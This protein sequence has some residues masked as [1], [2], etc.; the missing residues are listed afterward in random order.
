[1][2]SD[3]ADINSKLQPLYVD[4]LDV[5]KKLD[6]AVKKNYSTIETHQQKYNQLDKD[7]NEAEETLQYL[8]SSIPKLKKIN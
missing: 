6:L 5:K 3:E 7:I 8:K 1:M 4:R 2:T